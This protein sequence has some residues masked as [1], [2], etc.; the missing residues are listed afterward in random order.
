M[1]I[2]A[3]NMG[4]YTLVIFCFHAQDK[5][6]SISSDALDGWV[7]KKSHRFPPSSSEIKWKV[8]QVEREYHLYHCCC[9]SRWRLWLTPK[10]S[11]AAKRAEGSRGMHSLQAEQFFRGRSGVTE[12]QTTDRQTHTPP[13]KRRGYLLARLP[14]SSS[15]FPIKCPS[16]TEGRALG[17]WC[18]N[19][20]AWTSFSSLLWL[21]W[22]VVSDSGWPHGLW[23]PRLLCPWDFPGKNTGVA[24]YLLLQ[25]NLPNPGIEPAPP[26]LAGGFFT[27]EPPGK[28]KIYTKETKLEY[29]IDKTGRGS[30]KA[31]ENVPSLSLSLNRYS[32]SGWQIPGHTWR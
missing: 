27:T 10:R 30:F 3:W 9:W 15:N 6:L 22:Q 4:R 31:K 14:S 21:S 19:C 18:W 28:H 23:P 16:G 29:K 20:S 8:K 17:T 25:G 26:A 1:V 5:A 2:K 24:C 13:R 11:W 7:L 12:R 32:R